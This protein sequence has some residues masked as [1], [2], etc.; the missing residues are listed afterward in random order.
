LAE[1]FLEAAEAKLRRAELHFQTLDTLAVDFRSDAYRVESEKDWP[2]SNEIL[3]FAEPLREPP[4]VEWGPIIGDIVHNLRSALENAIWALSV[5]YSGPAP[6]HPLPKGSR[7]ADVRFPIT[8][9]AR[10]WKGDCAHGLWAIDP[11]L[12]T[13]IKEL[14]PFSTGQ[15]APEREPLAVLHELSNIDKH[16]YPHLVNATIELA[17]VFS[18]SPFEGAPDVD[19]E[20]LW[21]RAPGPLKERTQIAQINPVPRPPVLAMNLPEMHMDARFRPDVAFSEGHPAYGGRLTHT[22]SEI[23]QTVQAVIAALR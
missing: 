14:Q 5:A 4:S 22:L 18:V 6:K 19:F 15:N 20:V 23:G 13:P 7:W 1:S 21:K 8:L 16:A 9:R 3:I 11:K 2:K 10:D 12:W 17:D